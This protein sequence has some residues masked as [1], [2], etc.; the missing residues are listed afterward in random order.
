[1]NDSFCITDESYYGRSNYVVSISYE[2]HDEI[3][4][5][6]HGVPV[7]DNSMI[8]PKDSIPKLIEALKKYLKEE[9]NE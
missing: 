9:T 3:G 7:P 2:R 8:I 4:E 1:M 5:I 6:I